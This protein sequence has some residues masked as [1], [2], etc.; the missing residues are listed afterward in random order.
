MPHTWTKPDL[1]VWLRRKA[2]RLG[3]LPNND[4]IELS[5]RPHPTAWTFYKKFG[6]LADAYRA[7][8]LL[9]GEK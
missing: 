6:S 8:G 4:D 1:I 5:K 7:A 3:R 2:R 9:K